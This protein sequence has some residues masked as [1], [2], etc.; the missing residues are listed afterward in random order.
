MVP[1]SVMA[2]LIATHANQ[3][4]LL[5]NAKGSVWHGNSG[6][7]LQT[8]PQLNAML[9]GELAW[10]WE[11]SAALHGKLGFQLR[12]NGADAG[13]LELSPNL[14]TMRDLQMEWP[15][16][17][18]NQVA[19]VISAAHLGGKLTLSTQQL[20]ISNTEISGDL[21]M[22]FLHISSTLVSANPLGSYALAFNASQQ[23][24]LSI[25]LSTLGGN[26]LLSGQGQIT[27]SPSTQLPELSFD[28][29]ASA[30]PQHLNDLQELLHTLGNEQPNQDGVFQFHL[31]Q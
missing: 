20:R 24:S 18:L 3:G 7:W 21:M 1:A 4:L 27:L 13:Q 11:P 5:S 6:V 2:T 29:T 31:G 8:N 28:G 10:D 22:H 17:C 26:L 14:M 19:P 25:R 16:E 15:I 30:T 12:W 23:D 9:L